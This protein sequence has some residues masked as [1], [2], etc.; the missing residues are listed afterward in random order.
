MLLLLLPLPG[1]GNKQG[2]TSFGSGKQMCLSACLWVCVAL[3]CVVV[4]HYV[5][6]AMQILLCFL[7]MLLRQRRLW[8]LCYCCCCWCCCNWAFYFFI[9]AATLCVYAAMY[10]WKWVAFRI[11]FMF[12][13]LIKI[14]RY[15]MLRC[16]LLGGDA[17]RRIV[18][19]AW[20]YTVYS[21]I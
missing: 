14:V 8:G 15:F 10:V 1:N 7:L 9:V 13:F 21:R 19:L 6:F 11:F 16:T 12:I 20:G 3:C 5:A 2:A 4:A 18:M 17:I